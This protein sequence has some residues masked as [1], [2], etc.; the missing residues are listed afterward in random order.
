VTNSDGTDTLPAAYTFTAAD[1][2]VHVFNLTAGSATT[3]VVT[4]TL[5]ATDTTTGGVTAGITGTAA[6]TINPDLVATHFAVLTLPG[7]SAGS[8][9]RVAVVALD[10]NNHVAPTY[11]GTVTLTSTNSSDTLPSSYAFQASDHGVHVFQ[12]TFAVAGTDTVTA[13]D[14]SGLTGSL[15]VTVRQ[16]GAGHRWWF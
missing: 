4:D 9:T 16:P 12:A 11:T 5:T 10:A 8:P 3:A 2:G 14:G 15:A 6:L 13:T 7:A 1:H